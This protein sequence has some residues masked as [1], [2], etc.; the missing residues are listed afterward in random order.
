M[1]QLTDEEVAEYQDLKARDEESRARDAESQARD[2]K[3]GDQVGGQD[4]P[5]PINALT[6]EEIAEYRALRNAQRIREEEAAAVK[7]PPPTHTLVLAD[8]RTV[9]VAGTMTHYQDIPVVSSVHYVAPD[10]EGE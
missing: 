7:P 6:P 10:K 1:G 8:G 4:T 2:L 5:A 9:R 3:A